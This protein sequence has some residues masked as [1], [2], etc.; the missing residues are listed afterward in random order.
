[1]DI[2]TLRQRTQAARF[3]FLAENYTHDLPPL[4]NGYVIAL[5]NYSKTFTDV[6]GY[7]GSL[8]VVGD[9]LVDLDENWNPVW[10]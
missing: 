2:P 5:V 4:Q 9:G 7:P 10:A 3:D 1:V 8:D 6:R